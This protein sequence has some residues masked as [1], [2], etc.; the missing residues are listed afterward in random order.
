MNRVQQAAGRTCTWHAAALGEAAETAGESKGPASR[1]VYEKQPK[2]KVGSPRHGSSR[3][4]CIQFRSPGGA[5]LCRS[6]SPEIAPPRTSET[7]GDLRCPARHEPPWRMSHTLALARS[8]CS[9]YPGT[10]SRRREPR[11]TA[12]QAV[13]A[14][15]STLEAWHGLGAENLARVTTAAHRPWC[16]AMD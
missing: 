6:E 13:Y 8:R 14:V 11:R 7:H 9:V 2:P 1:R 3:P 12:Q 15:T 4:R 16:T 5:C 10:S